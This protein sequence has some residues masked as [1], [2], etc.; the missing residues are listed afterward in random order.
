MPPVPPQPARPGPAAGGGQHQPGT[1]VGQHAGEPDVRLR[2]I[3]RQHRRARVQHAQ[4]CH[5]HVLAALHE[6]GHRLVRADAA[7]P[8]PRRHRGGG[9]M[10]PAVGHVTG[11]GRSPGST[12]ATAFGARPA[13]RRPADAGQPRVGR[14]GALRRRAP[15]AAGRPRRRPGSAGAAVDRGG[16]PPRRAGGPAHRSAPRCRAQQLRAVLPDAG[17]LIAHLGDG[18]PTVQLRPTPGTG[19]VR[20]PVP[21]APT[22]RPPGTPR[23]RARSPSSGS[24]YSAA[25]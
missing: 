4:V 22:R 1:A 16:R 6:Q 7:A 5:D 14:A 9:A 24:P 19:T 21:A 8:Q 23:A 17:Q 20:R 25:S 15:R 18:Q 3:D 12:T 2:G 13:A 11:A 10:Q